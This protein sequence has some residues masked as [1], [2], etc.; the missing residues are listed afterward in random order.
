MG[1]ATNVQEVEMKIERL[2]CEVKSTLEN[3]ATQV[4][5]KKIISGYDDKIK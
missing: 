4:S 5:F 3:Y 1:N 2:K